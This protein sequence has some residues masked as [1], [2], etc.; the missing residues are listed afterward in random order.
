MKVYKIWCEWDMGFHEVYATKKLAQKDIDNIDW[1]TL[2]GRSQ[3]IVE[4]DGLVFIS[5]V[6]VYEGE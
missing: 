1:K 4:R 3:E 5:E 6:R 2:V